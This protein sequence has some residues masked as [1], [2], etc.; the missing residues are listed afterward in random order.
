MRNLHPLSPP[1]HKST[2]PQVHS[3]QETDSFN[4]QLPPIHY[5][6]TYIYF[7]IYTINAA[8]HYTSS[9]LIFSLFFFSFL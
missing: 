3:P 8:I 7:Y 6:Y 4:V 2:S 1:Y 9:P 5:I